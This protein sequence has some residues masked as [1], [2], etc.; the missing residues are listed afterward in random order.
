MSDGLLW[1]CQDIAGEPEQYLQH[2][3]HAHVCVPSIP[4]GCWILPLLLAALSNHRIHPNDAPVTPS[5]Y[6]FHIIV[7]ITI[8]SLRGASP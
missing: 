7:H 5:I 2:G 4:A 1:H 3:E 8:Y 6:C